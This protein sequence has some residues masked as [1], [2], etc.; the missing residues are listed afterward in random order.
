[1]RGVSPKPIWKMR[2][3]RL[4]RRG[5]AGAFGRCSI[6]RTPASSYARA[7]DELA[8]QL[9]FGRDFTLDRT[10]RQIDLTA[11]GQNRLEELWSLMHFANRGLL[12]GRRDFLTPPP[13]TPLASFE[14]ELALLHATSLRGFAAN[15]YYAPI[16]R[17]GFVALNAPL[18]PLVDPR[19]DGEDARRDLAAAPGHRLNQGAHP[20]KRGIGRDDRAGDLLADEHGRV[21]DVRRVA[22]SMPDTIEGDDRFGFSVMNKGKAKVDRFAEKTT[23]AVPSNAFV[24][25]ALASIRGGPNQVRATTTLPVASLAKRN[26]ENEPAIP[27]KPPTSGR[28]RISTAR[29]FPSVSTCWSWSRAPRTAR[30]ARGSRR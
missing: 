27:M 17:A 30:T 11:R 16:D 4:R 3:R 1:M 20:G 10:V 23:S 2:E 5:S 26:R 29:R 14:D 7:A 22:L 21:D 6:A 9:Q 8:G 18:R 13:T 19:F 25:A 28:I 15:P 24:F 12:G